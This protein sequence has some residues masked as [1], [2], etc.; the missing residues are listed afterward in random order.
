MPAEQIEVLA[1]WVAMGTPYPEAMLGDAE[2]SAKPRG[3][4]ITDKDKAFWSFQPLSHPQP[5]SLANA[6]SAWAATPVDSF[7]EAKL[8]DAGLQPNELASPTAAIRRLHFD[9]TG[10][11]PP[12]DLVDAFNRDPSDRHW[13]AIVDRLLASPE[14]GERWGRHWLDLV[15]YAET[16]SYERDGEKPEAWRYRD[17]VIRALNDDLPYDE[18]IRDQLA[19]DERPF[20][21][22]RLI[23][24]GFYRLGIWDDEPV[25]AEQARFDDLDDI[26]TTTSQVFSA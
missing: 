21:P 13:M 17:W 24:T 10:L 9:L 1:R 22:D 8:H 7:I 19:G 2:Q 20:T 16:N 14:Y 3:K 18:F 23:A 6:A 26:I 25:D 11:P 4:V 12:M 5:P 15:R